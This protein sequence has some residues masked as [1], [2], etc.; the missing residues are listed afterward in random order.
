MAGS[1]GDRFREVAA[2]CAAALRP[3]R[4]ALEDATRAL[5]GDG[6][7]G[8]TDRLK[9]SEAALHDLRDVLDVL[10]ADGSPHSCPRSA[11]AAAHV[12]GD[13]GRVVELTRQIVE[14]A[15]SWRAGGRRM[16]SAVRTAVTAVGGGVAELV[17]RAEDAAG[18][19]CSAPDADGSR[20]GAAVR[21]LD[22][23]FT[24]VAGSQRALDEVLVGRTRQEDTS[25]AVDLALLGR[26]Y[27]GCAW[28]ALAAVRHLAL[29]TG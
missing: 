20:L 28:H 11:V 2:L 17:G 4:E 1:G 27:E 22:R 9:A 25:L 26:C 24:G 7:R 3:A 21:E 15:W 13:M 14:T 16:P 18:L 8:G 6:G 5:A 10:Q 23:G 29:R 12:A 19:A